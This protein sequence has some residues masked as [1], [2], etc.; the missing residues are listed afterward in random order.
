MRTVIYGAG[1]LGTV[2][3]AYLAKAGEPVDLVNRNRAH[4]Q[5]LK[6]NGARITGT[7]SFTV[8]VHALLPE[9]MEG[10]YD[11]ILLMTKQQRNPEVVSSLMDYLKEDG[12]IVTFQNGLPE[13]GI[14]KI[15]GASRT[16]GCVVEWGATL[17]EP[18][19]AV[20]TS[21]PKRL[22][23]HMGRMNSV[24]E[25]KILAVKDLLEKMCPVILE[26]NLSGVR[27]T[28][29][30]INTAFSG[31]GTVT[32]KTYGEV[33][34][35]FRTR[36]G[37]IACMN[38]CAAVAKAEGIS[39]API[40]G[41]NIA[42]LFPCQTWLRKKMLML[43]IPIAMRKHSAI[44]PSMLQDIEKGKPCEIES[45]NAIITEYGRKNHVPTP[46]ND[47]ITEIIREID[48]GERKAATEN[49]ACFHDLF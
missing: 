44:Y 18:G 10:K 22:S 4:I 15:A 42:S 23:F 26:E 19:T 49:L 35:G 28:K 33:A 47:R 27:W 12:A 37:V 29:L 36:K 39:F 5:A 34:K 3:G 30:L 24:P 1:S 43:F 45:F 13:P 46:V 41:I 14:A 16:I 9:E 11:L 32:G 17:T 31:F 21:D 6:T 25:K 38:E 20:M 2:L 8:P 40:Q 7:V 48:R